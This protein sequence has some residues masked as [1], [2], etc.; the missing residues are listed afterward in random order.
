M[1]MWNQV[2]NMKFHKQ[3]KNYPTVRINSQIICRKKRQLFPLYFIQQK[4]I[5]I[6]SVSITV[7]DAEIIKDLVSDY[8]ANTATGTHGLS[9]NHL[10]THSYRDNFL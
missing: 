3:L 1:L 2:F 5:C 7:L 8:K 4:Y 6:Y 10:K 9:L